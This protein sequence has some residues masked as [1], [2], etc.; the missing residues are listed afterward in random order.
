ML[1]LGQT[2]PKDLK[3][4]TLVVLGQHSQ[5]PCLVVSS[6]RGGDKLNLDLDVGL[7]L[8]VAAPV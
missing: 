4:K 1:R 3:P 2:M 8:W 6:W 7:E 5:Q